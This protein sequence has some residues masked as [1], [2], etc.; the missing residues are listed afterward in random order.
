MSNI[1]E[2]WEKRF[3]EEY[4]ELRQLGLS[5]CEN[6]SDKL[7]TYTSFYPL[8]VDWTDSAIDLIKNDIPSENNCCLEDYIN[9][10]Q[11]EQNFR[12]TFKSLYCKFHN[13]I[14]TLDEILQKDKKDLT[15]PQEMNYLII[16]YG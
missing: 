3:L 4:W 8:V 16:C 5:L 2:D 7:K 15:K 10:Q 1:N 13:R 11:N 9:T 6:T 14:D 12:P